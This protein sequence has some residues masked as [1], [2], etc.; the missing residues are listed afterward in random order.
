[1]PRTNGKTSSM[2]RSSDESG[3]WRVL[4]AG[5]RGDVY[6]ALAAV[7]ALTVVSLWV[8]LTDLSNSGM[9][10]ADDGAQYAN[11]GAMMR[12]LILS[13]DWL[14]PIDFA[15][16][17]YAQYPAFSVP[18]HPPGYPLLLG[19]WFT[20]VGLS[21]ASARWFVAVC[22][23]GLASLFFG[24]LRKQ[25][26]AVQ[27]AFL[28]SLLL[29][30]APGIAR[31]SR[32]TMSEIPGLLFVVAGSLCFLYWVEKK[33]AGWCWA[34]F[35]LAL[36]A[37]FCRVL[38]AGVLPAW[39]LYLLVIRQWRRIRSPHLI[40]STAT[41]LAVC[42]SW[43]VFASGFATFETNLSSQDSLTWKSLALG[44]VALPEMVTWPTLVL[45]ILGIVFGWSR[46]RAI[47]WFWGLWLVSYYCFQV[48]LAAHETRYFLYAL[49]A[50]CGLACVMFTRLSGSPRSRLAVGLTALVLVA[51]NAVAVMSMPGGI[52]GHDRLAERM[53]TLREPGNVLLSTWSDSDLIF[54]Y[55]SRT[56]TS[57]QMIRGDR[58]LAIRLP[59]YAK[60]PPVPLAS[61]P[62]VVLDIV[63]R[64]RIR[65]VVTAS[66]IAPGPDDRPADM[67]LAHQ[68]VTSMPEEF[69]LLGQ[70]KLSFDF[71][72]HREA[73]LFLWRFESELPPGESELQVVIPTAGIVRDSGGEG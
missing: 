13:G 4:P 53:V 55:R 28:V 64:G 54:H 69:S 73:T 29:V 62:E 56:T 47:I 36:M 35:A 61:E 49:P 3:G 66:A 10:W 25:G 15:K 23:A 2:S 44:L 42:G 11:G 41:Y 58:T 67:R 38:T 70:F 45:G 32:S 43:A 33:K 48:A 39:F 71:A 60:V 52:T 7:L 40:A 12:D 16:S 22:L 65:Y 24:I 37:F 6:L 19:L 18:Y 63:R 46:S 27:T 57:R 9:Q 68:A 30:T 50:I 8:G 14:H 5:V 20:A 17:N 51:M 34:A 31:W 26:A 21:Y 1:M 72:G 59:E